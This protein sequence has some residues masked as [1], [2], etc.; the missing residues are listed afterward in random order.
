MVSD[1]A[2]IRSD[3]YGRQ[4]AGARIP[5]LA[6]LSQKT[7][8][9][10]GTGAIGA[11]IALDLARAGIGTLRLLE[12]DHIEAATTVRWPLGIAAAGCNKA[13]ALGDHIAT[14]WPYTHV[15]GA[16][17]RVGAAQLAGKDELEVLDALLAGSHLLLDATAELSVQR[18]LADVARELGMPYLSVSAADGAWGGVVAAL[19]PD[20][21]A[22]WYCIQWAMAD[23]TIEPPP[24][25]TA[26]V[27][28]VGCAS[29]T[30]T[31]A[32]F[33][34]TPVAAMATRMAVMTLIG[35]TYGEGAWDVAVLA[36]RDAEG[37]PLP[38]SWTTY[39]ATRHPRCTNHTPH[40]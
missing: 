10:I 4:D 21:E 6:E 34:L 17:M 19:K 29:P 32:N 30:F 40:H 12:H 27:Q 22:C 25:D 33:D 13:E 14:N 35:E 28:P 11:P 2:L 1:P 37:R 3:R 18:A 20:S 8:T 5:R 7:V 26:T 24:A 38:G 31:G 9:V 15:E 16:R 36:L 23:G 39:P